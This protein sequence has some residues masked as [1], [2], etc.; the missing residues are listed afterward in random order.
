MSPEQVKGQGEVDHRA[1]LWALGC[2]AYECLTGRPVWTTEQ[3]VAM[4]FAQIASAP[5]PRPAA[6]PARS[7]AVVHDVVRE[8]ARARLDEALPDRAGARRRARRRLPNRSRSSLA[9]ELARCLAGPTCNPLLATSQRRRLGR[10]SSR[11]GGAANVAPSPDRAPPARARRWR[12]ISRRPRSAGVP[13]RRPRR[14]L[15]AR[16]GRTPP[17]RR[18]PVARSGRRPAAAA[19]GRRPAQLGA[20]TPVAAE[21]CARRAPRARRG[22]AGVVIGGGWPSSSR[23]ARR[24]D[25]APSSSRAGDAPSASASARP[26][27]PPRPERRPERRG[28][29]EAAERPAWMPHGAR[30]RSRRS[31]TGDLKDA[32]NAPARRLREGRRHGVPRTHD[33]ARR[34]SRRRAAEGALPAH[35]ARAAARLRPPG[36][37]SKPAPRRAARRSR[38]G[39]ERR[40]SSSWTDA[41]EGAGARLRRAARRAMRDAGA[42]V[43]VTPEGTLGR[44]A[45][46]PAR[47]RSA[48]RS[49]TGTRRAPRPASTRASSTR[50]G[51]IAGPAMR[52]SPAAKPGSARP[53]SRARPTARSGSPGAT[54]STADS[55]DLFL[56]HLGADARAVGR[57]DRAPPTCVPR[58]PSKPRVAAALASPSRAARSQVAFRLERDPL[59]VIEL[60]RLADRRDAGKGLEPLARGERRDGPRARRGRRSSTPTRPRPT[61]RRSRAAAAAAS[62]CGTAS[63]RR[64]LRGVHRAR[65][66]PSRSGARSSPSG[67][68]P[69]VAVAPSGRRGARLVRGRQGHDGADHPRRRRA[70]P[71]RIARVS[72][73]QPPPS[74][75]G[76]R[77]SPGE[78]YVAWLDYETG[79]LEAYAARVHLQVTVACS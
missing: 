8:G 71:R 38:I 47:G 7:A 70:R 50:D 66:R 3:G 56:R 33:G 65:R 58:G 11:R 31:P 34:R 20:V 60:M 9:I 2:I 53:S 32:L 57:R 40:R 44:P 13:R 48:R 55:E 30:R 63:E 23:R 12:P 75:V 29:G 6:L 18:S 51:R 25:P 52:P 79:H 42:P 10:A 61:P 14:R 28:S 49:S 54:R 36:A 5:L 21:R 68:H 46:A 78:W 62:S 37:A 76:G 22:A 39:P 59:H 67:G 73:D 64:R 27:S 77:R 15:G 41:H 26:A 74:I 16:P 17:G 43:D 69:S 24:V 19:L 35:R 45:G 4:T 1:D 72:G